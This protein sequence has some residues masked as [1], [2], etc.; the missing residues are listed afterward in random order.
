MYEECG[1]V[2]DVVYVGKMMFCWFVFWVDVNDDE[3]FECVVD[4]IVG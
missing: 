3:V 1:I 4:V 2:V